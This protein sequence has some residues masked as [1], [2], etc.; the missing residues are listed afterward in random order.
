MFPAKPGSSRSTPLFSRSLEEQ[1]AESA[2]RET[3]SFLP[4]AG[5][6]VSLPLITCAAL[7]VVAY[8]DQAQSRSA[9]AI[10]SGI[11]VQPAAET[12]GVKAKALLL[13]QNTTAETETAPAVEPAAEAIQ[14]K[15]LQFYE[16]SMLAGMF[17]AP[18]PPPPPQ[19]KPEPKPKPAPTPPVVVPPVNPFADWAYVGTVKTDDQIMVLLEN[20][21]TKEG[22]FLHQGDSFMGARVTTATE[23][24]VTLTQGDKPYMLAKSDTITVTP[25]DK[26]AA[27]LTAPPPSQPGQPGMPGQPMGF[28]P[29]RN[30]TFILPNGQALTGDMAELRN[31]WM[32]RRFNGG[33]GGGG[34]G[35]GGFGGRGFG[36]RVFGGGGQ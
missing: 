27:F 13:A 17:S 15:P 26:S 31:R 18:Q 34:R 6:V 11:S 4:G 12:A 21:K 5:L 7:M 22:K 1:Q 36:G 2:L 32:N 23:Q 28:Q 25:L 16:Q 29:G 8:P 30:G 10:E 20:T 33:G 9:Q 24:M 19:P 3:R 35:F 14:R